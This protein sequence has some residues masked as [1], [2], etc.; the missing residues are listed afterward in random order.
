MGKW[1]LMKAQS[2]LHAVSTLPFSY[3]E[4]FSLVRW[5]DPQNRQDCF[6]PGVMIIN[7]FITRLCS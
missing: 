6:H 4:Y 2:T 3:L 7:V 1:F 5:I